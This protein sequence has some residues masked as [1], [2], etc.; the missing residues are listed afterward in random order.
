MHLR[1]IRTQTPRLHWIAHSLMW[2]SRF[3][4]DPTLSRSSCRQAIGSTRLPAP[5]IA[6]ENCSNRKSLEAWLAQNDRASA[7]KLA[8]RDTQS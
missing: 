1:A 6:G 4:R 8:E 5:S 7:Q 3:P 2:V